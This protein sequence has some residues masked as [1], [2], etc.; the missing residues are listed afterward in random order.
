MRVRIPEARR[1]IAGEREMDTFI[2]IDRKIGDGGDTQDLALPRSSGNLTV[3]DV[4]GGWQVVKLSK[5][6]KG[7]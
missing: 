2:S 6:L 5:R 1:I 4:G 3:K 7:G